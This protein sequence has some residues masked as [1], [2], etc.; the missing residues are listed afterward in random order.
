MKVQTYTLNDTAH[1][2]AYILDSQISYGVHRKRPA[3][4]ICPG[5]GYL[6]LATKEGEAVATSFLS[7]GYHCFVLRYS[8][9][10]LERV[11]SLEETPIIN[12]KA[13]YPQP[14]LELMQTMLLL[15]ENAE[16]WCLDVDNIFVTGFS[17]G[18]HLAASLG[19]HWNNPDFHKDLVQPVVVEKLK[20]K[21]LVLAYPLLDGFGSDYIAKNTP[22]EHLIAHQLSDMADFFFQTQQPTQAKKE[23]VS[24]LPFIGETTPPTFLWVTGQDQ[25]VDPEACLS[26]AMK[27]QELG[28]DCE[29]HL[30]S[31]GSHGLARADKVYA[32]TST[33]IKPAV[34]VWMDMALTWLDAQ[35]EERN[36]H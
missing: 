31:S 11:T 7:Q 4:I 29:C 22:K 18:G 27:L 15:H 14:I 23:A 28:I 1:V 10:H 36:G 19:V 26:Y 32:K 2:T 33:E 30:F 20:P 8:T 17:A 9:Y 6:T 35:M 12:P 3:M 21:G 13:R 34:A 25:I 24:I 16:E 5:G